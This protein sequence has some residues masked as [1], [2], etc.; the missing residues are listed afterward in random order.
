MGRVGSR[1]PRFSTATAAAIFVELYYDLSHARQ[2][3]RRA[4]RR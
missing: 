3:E 4:L 1:F 2:A